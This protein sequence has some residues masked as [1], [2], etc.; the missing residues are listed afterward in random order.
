MESSFF[1]RVRQAPWEL[2][3]TRVTSTTRPAEGPRRGHARAAKLRCSTQ[4][5]GP[6]AEVFEGAPPRDV[7]EL[8]V[9]R[10]TRVAPA[11]L[12][13]RSATNSR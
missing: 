13:A 5:A 2:V 3:V 8:Q 12:K 11:A 4:G 7:G 6:T 1:V 10:A 9:F